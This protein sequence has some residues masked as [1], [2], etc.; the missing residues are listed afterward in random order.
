MKILIYYIPSIY[1]TTILACVYVVH[2]SLNVVL[3]T[4]VHLI[5][6]YI[7]IFGRIS[8]TEKPIWCLAMPYKCM[9]TNPN[10][11]L[12]ANFQNFVYRVKID[13]WH[14]GF[15]KGT[16]YIVSKILC[17]VSCN[18][19]WRITQQCV[20]FHLIL[21]CNTVVLW[22]NVCQCTRILQLA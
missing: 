6:W 1:T 15:C 20:W 11:V 3:H 22:L 10:S 4:F 12:I 17:G 5:L 16:G 2:N 13:F 21:Q 8:Y 9:S 7:T 19:G 14:I 18:Q